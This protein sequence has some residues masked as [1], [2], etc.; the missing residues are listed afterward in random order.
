MRN[1]STY[2][3]HYNWDRSEPT[4]LRIE[5]FFEDMYIGVVYWN[6]ERH[7]DYRPKAAVV[8][9]KFIKQGQPKLF[10]SEMH[11]EVGVVTQ[12]GHRFTIYCRQWT[13]KELYDV[14][15]WNPKSFYWK[16]TLSEKFNNWLAK[17]Y[18]DE[19]DKALQIIIYD[20]A[21]EVQQALQEAADYRE[22]LSRER[23]EYE[24][25]RKIEEAEWQRKQA[26]L[27]KKELEARKT[28]D[29]MFGAD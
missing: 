4:G 17:E 2:T 22:K 29:K 23:A 28:I 9:V 19:T 26:E 16:W 21:L 13:E 1:K 25:K 8:K 27:T 3:R 11:H 7:I 12:D 10:D 24:A 20:T 5:D 6:Y 18:N 15:H 14:N